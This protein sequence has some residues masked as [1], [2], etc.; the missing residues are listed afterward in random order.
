[1]SGILSILAGA[2]GGLFDL[3]LSN[4]IRPNV[5]ALLTAAGY[6]GGAVRLYVAPNANV[7]TLDLPVLPAGSI[8]YIGAGA[9]I[10]PYS[11]S[12][13]ALRVRSALAIENFGAIKG[14][15]GEG[16]TGGAAQVIKNQGPDAGVLMR[17]EGGAGSL[18]QVMTDGTLTPST[19]ATPVAGYSLF[20][21]PSGFGGDPGATA[22]SG[23]GGYGGQLGL[24]GSA[25]IAGAIS[26]Y[27]QS[28]SSVYAGEP[29]YSPGPA[30][31]G[32][33]FITWVRKGTV[34]GS[35]S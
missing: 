10:A 23:R 9:L 32:T 34:Q 1:M 24:P 33:A 20:A 13:P 16:G 30:V 3:N 14:A 28:G 22:T 8:L 7:N 11:Y 6:T 31:A 26:G 5:T 19:V 27:Y 12:V 25:G 15:G 2:G 4:K 17:A 35:E 18:G 29:G 21:R